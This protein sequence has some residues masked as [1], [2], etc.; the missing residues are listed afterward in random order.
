MYYTYIIRCEDNSLYT[1]IAS[2]LEN[3]MT[4]HSSRNEK[5]AKYTMSHHAVK[6]ETAFSSNTKSLA[7]KL[8][9]HIKKRLSKQ[10]KEELIENYKLL[11]A[12]S[13]DKID[14]KEYKKV[15]TTTLSKINKKLF[16]NI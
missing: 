14:Y 16:F 5:C 4:E 2:D 8:E 7:S 3:R 12:F 10:Q 1:G 13:K 11:K 15:R 9:Y 6:I